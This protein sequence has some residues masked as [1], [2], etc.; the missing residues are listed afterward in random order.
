[1]FTGSGG[2]FILRQ[3]A[4]ARVARAGGH[5]LDG[6]EGAKRYGD[7]ELPHALDVKYPRAGKQ[8]HW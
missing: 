8:W 2:L 6:L 5:C 1:M 3:G 7:V 4:P